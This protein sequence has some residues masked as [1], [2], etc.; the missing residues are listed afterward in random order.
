[1]LLLCY[2]H[3]VTQYKDKIG[4]VCDIDGDGDVQV[5]YEERKKWFYN[6]EALVKV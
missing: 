5:V 6:P 4:T 1:M 3:I 2:E